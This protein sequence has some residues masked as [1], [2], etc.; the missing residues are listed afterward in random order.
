MKTLRN[1]LLFLSAAAG[2]FAQQWEIGG[3]V[4]AT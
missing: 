2:A 1:S 4:G 3:N